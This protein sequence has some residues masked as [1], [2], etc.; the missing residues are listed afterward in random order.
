MEH[1]CG[2]GTAVCFRLGIR[3]A[4]LSSPVGFFHFWLQ[5]SIFEKHLSVEQVVA[6]YRYIR[7]QYA[8]DFSDIDFSLKCYLLVVI[9]LYVEREK[10]VLNLGTQ[11]RIEF[12]SSLLKQL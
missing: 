6:D 5:T 1:V 11:Q 7:Q 10:G 9:A 8:N 12:W 4:Y 2:V 3:P